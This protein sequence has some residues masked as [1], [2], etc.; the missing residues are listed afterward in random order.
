MSVRKPLPDWL[1]K[2]PRHLS[3]PLRYVTFG[4]VIAR[5]RKERGFNQTEFARLVGISRNYVSTIE[6]DLALNLSIA[7]L[8][9]LA[10]VLRID[11]CELLMIYDP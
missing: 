7:I 5:K 9:R 6:R 2:P 3:M 11:K 4:D 10:L 8:L 1:T